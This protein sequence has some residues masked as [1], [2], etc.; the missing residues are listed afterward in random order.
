[1]LYSDFADTIN[2][3]LGDGNMVEVIYRMAID[4]LKDRDRPKFIRQYFGV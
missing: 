3:F 2:Q 1:M 4:K